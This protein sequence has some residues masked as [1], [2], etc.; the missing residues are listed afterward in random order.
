MVWTGLRKASGGSAFRQRDGADMAMKMAFAVQPFEVHRKRLLPARQ[1]PAHTESGTVKKAEKLAM[2]MPGAAAL[3]VVADDETGELEGLMILG[4]WGEIPDDFA[5]SLQGAEAQRSLPRIPR[6]G[7]QASNTTLR[8]TAYQG[9][10]EA[11]SGAL[12]GISIN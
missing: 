8:C 3:T 4:R 1:E 11:A 10:P 9:M 7:S 2:R 12:C 5:D 6:S